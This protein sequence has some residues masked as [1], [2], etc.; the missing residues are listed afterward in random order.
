MSRFLQEPITPGA[1][2]CQSLRGV[3]GQIRGI[4]HDQSGSG[5]TP[6]RADEH[7]RAEQQYRSPQ[8]EDEEE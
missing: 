8:I 4:V 6:D 7:R 3:L 1:A 5:A 2:S